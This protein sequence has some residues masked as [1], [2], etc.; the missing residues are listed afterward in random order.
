MSVNLKGSIWREGGRPGRVGGSGV[1]EP[2]GLPANQ[3][4]LDGLSI[5]GSIVSNTCRNRLGEVGL[6]GQ[7]VPRP[8]LTF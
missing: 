7:N 5:L 2:R 4:Q 8:D 3:P 6:T 1:G